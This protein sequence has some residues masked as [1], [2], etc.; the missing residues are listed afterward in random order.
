LA[1][2]RRNC[3]ALHGGLSLT[4]WQVGLDAGA[5]SDSSWSGWDELEKGEELMWKNGD[6]VRLLVRIRTPI[7]I[8]ATLCESRTAFRYYAEV[9]AT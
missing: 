2:L 9:E 5:V 4:P 6:D 3:A 1:G 8:L 7:L